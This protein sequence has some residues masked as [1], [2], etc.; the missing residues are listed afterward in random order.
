MY[1]GKSPNIWDHYFHKKANKSFFDRV[2]STI[3]QNVSL[4]FK[5]VDFKDVIHPA[6]ED[7]IGNGDIACNSYNLLDE[8][9]KNLVDLKV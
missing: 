4:N 9:I 2:I 3:K 5:R 1:T 6:D 7:K 8:D